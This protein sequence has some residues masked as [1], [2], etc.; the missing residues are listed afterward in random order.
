[1]RHNPIS[2]E[3]FTASGSVSSHAYDSGPNDSPPSKTCA[4]SEAAPMF[5]ETDVP[6]N[7][8]RSQKAQISEEIL[9]SNIRKR[10][11]LKYKTTGLRNFPNKKWRKRSS[12]VK[13]RA[14]YTSQN[15]AAKLVGC[16]SLDEYDNGSAPTCCK[17]CCFD[18]KSHFFGDLNS[19]KEELKVWWGPDSSQAKRLGLLHDDILKGFQFSSEPNGKD[20]QRWFILGKEVCKIFYLRAR[21]MQKSTVNTYCKDF[22]AGRVTYL[23]AVARDKKHDNAQERSPKRHS[24]TVWLQA[25]AKVVGDKLPEE[26]VTVLPFRR[27]R[28]L[29][30]E[31]FD[32]MNMLGFEPAKQ[33]HFDAVFNE[34]SNE[35]KIRLCRDTGSFVTCNVCDAYHSRLRMAKSLEE[36]EQIKE[37]RRLHIAKQRKQR[38]KYYKHKR[39][40]TEN[41]NKY[42]SII[43]D[44]MDQKKTNLPVMGRYTKTESPLTQRI[45]G[46]KVHGIK[47][48]AFVVDETVPGG[49]NLMVEILRRVLLDLQEKHKLPS[50]SKCTLFLQVDNCG[51]N[52][53]K[54]MFGFLT[55]LVR[56][57]IFHKVKAGFLMVGHTHE[58]IDQFFSTIATHLKNIETLCPDQ[59]SLFQEIRNAFKN[60]VDQPDIFCLQASEIFDYV[61][62]YESVLDPSLAH[63]QEPHQ[64]RIKTFYDESTQSST[65]LVHYKMWCHS[66]H[67]LPF[68]A[69]PILS[70]TTSEPPTKK[71]KMS[72]FQV[73]KGQALVANLKKAIKVKI[74]DVPENEGYNTDSVAGGYDKSKDETVSSISCLPGISWLSKTP[75]LAN[76]P[77]ISFSPQTV[78]SN[79]QK[80]QKIY[81]TVVSLFALLNKAVFTDSVITNWQMWLETQKKLWDPTIHAAAQ[82]QHAAIEFPPS[83]LQRN[84]QPPTE[85]VHSVVEDSALADLADDLEFVTHNSSSHGQFSKS[86]RLEMVRTTLLDIEAANLSTP[87]QLNMGCIYSFT[88]PNLIDKVDVSQIGLGIV[89]KIHG[90]PNSPDALVD[91]QFCPPKGAKPA[92]SKR[93][94]TLYQNIHANMSFNLHYISRKGKKVEAEDT[95]L[96]RSVML[97]FNLELNKNGTICQRR[98]ADSRYNCSSYDVANSVISKYYDSKNSHDT[99]SSGVSGIL[100]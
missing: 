53:N 23:G 10:L 75:S 27:L 28:A 100:N 34:V 69:P 19:L 9:E 18:C 25:F 56:E 4:H 60:S 85:L 68:R 72:R 57:N 21:G 84:Q 46:V 36:R 88:Y 13:L 62:Y 30:E 50:D 76:A 26:A 90:Q 66:K 86:D 48:Y 20:L 58:D 70:A 93:Q 17:S 29:H 22:L 91:I 11:H 24:I 97:A 71:R 79:Y 7:N 65:V 14:R 63:H 54:T 77:K 96:P 12:E 98:M 52:K 64:F 5:G 2:P 51:E 39:K 83:I 43:M 16:D 92:T 44:G 61:N 6:T 37:L 35:L 3:V 74:T 94:D 73:T 38:E 67:W 1:M 33:R 59:P 8:N 15:Y 41:P 40:A 78:E 80:V 87:I 32:D 99:D 81:C 55:H 47:N 42:M 49:S 95:N 82:H 89:T 45:I 31:Y